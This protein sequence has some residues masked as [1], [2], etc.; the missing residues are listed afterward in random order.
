MCWYVST[1]NCM[2]GSAD[3]M[4]AL[5]EVGF[6]FAGSGTVAPAYQGA[7]IALRV[8]GAV[9]RGAVGAGRRVP[10]RVRR[11]WRR[12]VLFPDQSSHDDRRDPHCRGEAVRDPAADPISR[13]RCHG[14]PGATIGSTRVFWRHRC[15]AAPLKR[16]PEALRE[17][18]TTWIQRG[19]TAHS[20]GECRGSVVAD[21]L[22]VRARVRACVPCP[23]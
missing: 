19:A 12:L 21:L 22:Y 4:Q 18:E 16:F 2:R 6:R 14:N 5:L 13:V 1:R 20:R 9:R 15:P 8:C 3:G 17:E 7:P 10:A 11:A 23:P